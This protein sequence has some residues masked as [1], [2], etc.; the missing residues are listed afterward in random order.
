MKMKIYKFRAIDSCES[1]ERA[2]QILKTGQFWCSRFWDMNDPMEGIYRLN[3]SSTAG[4]IENTFEHKASQV[5]CCF[6]GEEA[7][8]NAAMWGYYANGFKGVAIE[9]DVDTA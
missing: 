1:F 6:S 9:I 3:E 4:D 5:I 7:L 8:K 2:S